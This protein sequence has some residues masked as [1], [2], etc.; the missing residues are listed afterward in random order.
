MQWYSAVLSITL[1]SAEIYAPQPS[2]HSISPIMYIRVVYLQPDC[3][4]ALCPTIHPISPSAQPPLVSLALH[5]QNRSNHV[6]ERLRKP[7]PVPRA[8]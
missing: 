7:L 6:A 1:S 2:M 8:L 5:L 4:P 3:C